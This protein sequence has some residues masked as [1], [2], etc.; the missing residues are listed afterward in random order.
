MSKLFLKMELQTREFDIISS[1][2]LLSFLDKLFLYCELWLYKRIRHVHV[3]IHL[4]TL[5]CSSLRSCRYISQ[6]HLECHYFCDSWRRFRKHRR[7]TDRRF[8]FFHLLFFS[9]LTMKLIRSHTIKN[10]ILLWEDLQGPHCSLGCLAQ[11][12]TS[13]RD[14]TKLRCISEILNIM[15]P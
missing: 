11:T 1:S 7:K 9:W 8:A 5:Q 12:K 3:C 13:M 2:H 4:W 15:N 10:W 14:L 6:I